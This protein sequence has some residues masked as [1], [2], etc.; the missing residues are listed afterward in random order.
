[1]HLF[2]FL[3]IIKHCSRDVK[4]FEEPTCGGAAVISVVLV[5]KPHATTH[6]CVG[7]QCEIIC[8]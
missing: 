6:F 1:M 8:Q 4:A 2:F 3:F 5:S 7:P